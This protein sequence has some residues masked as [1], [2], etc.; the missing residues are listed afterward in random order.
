MNSSVTTSNITN[1]CLIITFSRVN[2]PYQ[3]HPLMFKTE[4]NSSKITIISFSVS[5]GR[6]FSNP[7]LK[8]VFSKNLWIR[9][10]RIFFFDSMVPCI[11]RRVLVKR[12]EFLLLLLFYKESAF[13]EAKTHFFDSINKTISGRFES[14]SLSKDS[15]SVLAWA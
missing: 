12:F 9:H 10:C 13:E 11:Y 15:A 7:L 8:M 2:N 1:K 3:W 5:E 4:N 6:V 14:I